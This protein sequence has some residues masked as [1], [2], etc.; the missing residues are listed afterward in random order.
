M[1]ADSVCSQIPPP[2]LVLSSPHWH[3]HGTSVA[4]RS[5]TLLPKENPSSSKYSRLCLLQ[6]GLQRVEQ[7][8]RAH[9]QRRTGKRKALCLRTSACYS[10]KQN[11]VSAQNSNG[12][13]FAAQNLLLAWILP[14]FPRGTCKQNKTGWETLVV[15][16]QF[17]P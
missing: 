8:H 9:L 7:G 3:S 5:G 2:T 1:R 15:F 12:S 6:G 10:T 16:P 14:Y 13:F 17:S 4:E 11:P